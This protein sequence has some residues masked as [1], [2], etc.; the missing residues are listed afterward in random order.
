[1]AAEPF[2]EPVVSRAPVKEIVIVRKIR[3]RKRHFFG[4]A[5]K[6]VNVLRFLKYFARAL[7]VMRRVGGTDI[8]VRVTDQQRLRR[9]R[10][11]QVA[12]VK[13]EFQA[14]DDVLFGICIRSRR[15]IVGARHI[16]G[17]ALHNNRRL[18]SWLNR[19]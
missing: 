14:S 7:F 16:F 15:F 18:D 13:A 5:I 3:S 10:R 12:P 4:R 11:E 17:V 6:R 9:K 19:A 8:H 1:M 2:I